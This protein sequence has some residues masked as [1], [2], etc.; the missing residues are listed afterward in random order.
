M[1]LKL[2]SIYLYIVKKADY[3]VFRMLGSLRKKTL[4]VFVS[5]LFCC[6]F[7]THAQ[8][9]Q[10]ERDSLRTL[11]ILKDALN[12]AMQNNSST[13]SAE[14]DM[15][16]DGLIMD[17][18]ISKVGRDFFDMFYATWSAPKNAKNFTITIKEMVLP[19]LAT[20]ITILVND[21]EV[22]KQ[23]VQPRNDIMEQMSN[24]AIYK[25]TRYLSNYERMKSQ[26]DG[27]DQSGSGIF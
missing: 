21:E 15:E 13:E 7:S 23:R 25:T 10:K 4:L 20:Q 6:S 12:S 1:N 24:Y 26:L 22:F 17:E 8:Q 2:E 19:G 27:D 11:K 5:L 3:I 16:I 9:S 14:L 18:T